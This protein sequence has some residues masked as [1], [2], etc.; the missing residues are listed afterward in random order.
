MIKYVMPLLT[1]SDFPIAKE[2][3]IATDDS[4]P[5]IAWPE[6]WAVVQ[7]DGNIP[8]RPYNDDCI[9]AIPTEIE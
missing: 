8:A 7:T 4:M 2:I 6:N 3:N 5:E 9:T 1:A